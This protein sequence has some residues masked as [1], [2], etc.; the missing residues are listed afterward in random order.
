MKRI[1]VKG[2]EEI[3]GFALI[4]I[5]V[6]VIL[7]VI[8]G[9]SIRG[10]GGEAVQSY[11]VGSFLQASLQYTSDCYD[12]IEYLPV[13]KLIFE[14]ENENLCED[15]RDTCDILENDFKGIIEKSWKVSEE[16]PVKGYKIAIVSQEDETPKEILSIKDGNETNNYKTSMQSF[17]RQGIDYDVS[18][19]VYY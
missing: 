14:C 12:G 17:S 15:D 8:L 3:V 1:K 4:I 7:L 13:Q 9:L 19:S 18:F 11:E 5:I 6:A 16:M 2:Q 10:K